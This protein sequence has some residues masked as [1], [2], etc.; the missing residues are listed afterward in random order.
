[1]KHS[2]TLAA[3]L[4]FAGGAASAEINV[5]SIVADYQ[6]Q[7]Y[8]RIEVVN[9]LT[10][11]KL[12]AIR[13]TEKLEVVL[14]RATGAV[15]KSETETVGAFENTQ[16]GISVRDRNRDFVR[17]ASAEDKDDDAEDSDHA[18][19]SDDGEDHDLGDDH[20]S[21]D[22]HNSDGHDSDDHESDDHNSD[23]HDSDGH[24]GSGDSDSD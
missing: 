19:G 16:P 3:F 20:G 11:T 13:G 1:M 2:L 24:D 8:S 12:E 10:Q 21:D 6:A 23:G 18:T 7:G 5:D 15:L 22:D 9:G 17:L 14:D 4:A